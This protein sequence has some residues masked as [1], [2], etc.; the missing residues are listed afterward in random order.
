MAEPH[1]PPLTRT[2]TIGPKL[3]QSLSLSILTSLTFYLGHGTLA[4]KVL[5]PAVR[6]SGPKALDDPKSSTRP[7]VRQDHP[8]STVYVYGC[9]GMQPQSGGKFCPRLNVGERPIEN[10]YR[11]CLKLSGGKRMGA[12]DSSRSDAER[13]N[14]HAPHGVPRHLH[15]QGVNLWAPH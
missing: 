2:R 15:A 9:L 12:G 7:Q 8:L 4:F 5:R 3:E 6:R 1:G 13:S 10:K 14:P 11:E